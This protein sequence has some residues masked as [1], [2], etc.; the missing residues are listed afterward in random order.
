MG[1]KERVKRYIDW[2]CLLLL[3]CEKRWCSDE[4]EIMKRDDMRVYRNAIQ[5]VLIEVNYV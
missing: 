4:R 5:C 2:F 3:T 1:I